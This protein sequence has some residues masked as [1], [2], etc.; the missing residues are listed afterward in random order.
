MTHKYGS[1]NFNPPCQ[2]TLQWKTNYSWNS[3]FTFPDLNRVFINNVT[4]RYYVYSPRDSTI[5]YNGS[6]QSTA[7]SVALAETLVGIEDA[8]LKDQLM[9]QVNNR[10]LTIY[11]ESKTVLQLQIFDLNGKLLIEDRVSSN[12]ATVDLNN[13]GASIYLM[14]LSNSKEILAEKLSM[15]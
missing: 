4:P 15:Q 3:I 7:F 14:R 12:V 5:K 2:K 9:W 13:L 11:N 1:V 10:Q 8:Q 6:V